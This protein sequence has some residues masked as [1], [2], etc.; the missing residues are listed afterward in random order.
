MVG[1]G[2]GGNSWLMSAVMT[3]RP[4]DPVYVGKPWPDGMGV[5]EGM[6][7]GGTPVLD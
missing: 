6:G 4:L 1:G 3:V 2:G 7:N 5:A